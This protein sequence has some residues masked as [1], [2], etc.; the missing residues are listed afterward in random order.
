MRDISLHILDIAENSVDA[1]ATKVEITITEN[2]EAD[3]FMLKVVDDGRGMDPD[4]LRKIEDPFFTM[5][6]G[7]R[8]GLGIPFLAQ[9]AGQCGG[10]LVVESEKGRGTA[11]TAEFQLSHI[12]RQPLGDVASSV[13]AMV[14]GHPD[15]DF[16]LHYERDGARYSFGTEGLRKELQGVPL[17]LPEVLNLIRDDI[18][19]GIRRIKDEG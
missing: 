18:N 1:G 19:D 16:S 12:D 7:K 5:K 13:V 3:R 11:V 17:N 10:E 15:V 9:A 2:T 14:C 8:W 4:L 6:E